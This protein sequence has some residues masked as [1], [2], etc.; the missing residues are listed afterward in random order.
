MDDNF[1][2]GNIKRL[3]DYDLNILNDKSFPEVDDES[4]RLEMLINEKEEALANI[5]SKIKGRELIGKLLDV[6]ELKIQAK[7]LENEI[8]ELKEEFAR[9][10]FKLRL[11][12]QK[13]KEKKKLPLIIRFQRFVSRKLFAKISKKFKSIADLGD[14]LDTLA[15]INENVDELIAMKV[16]YG[17]TKAN[18]E[19]LTNYLYRANRIHSEIARKMYMKK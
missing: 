8:A 17:E 19:K 10:N 16:P 2:K 14:S 12:P 3:N 13:K 6:M 15:S 1:F 7:E 4:L 5:N 9:N 11:K 18:Y